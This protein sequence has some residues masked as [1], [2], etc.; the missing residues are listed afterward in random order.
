MNNPSIAITGANGFVGS[1][2]VTS[3]MARGIST[4]K[5]VRTLSAIPLTE[6]RA[7]ELETQPSE[8]L[9]R[10]IDV[11]IH[12][13][14]VSPTEKNAASLDYNGTAALIALAR[15]SGVQKIIFF[16]TVS[17]HEGAVSAY[18]SSKYKMEQLLD[19]GKDAIV[20]PAL[21]IGNGG[22]FLRLLNQALSKRTVPLI[23]NGKQ[24]MQV[25]ALE[26]VVSAVTAIID[27]NLTGS[28]VLANNENFSYKEMFKQIASVYGVYLRFL[29][30]PVFPVKMALSISE[31]IGVKLPVNKENLS[32]LQSLKYMDPG[33]SL[34][35][36]GLRPLSF[37][38]ALLKVKELN[39]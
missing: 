7:F 21:I 8:N 24:P 32:G 22:L 10:G 6:E 26:D 35:K 13:A 9:L 27:R 14:F 5:L 2:L 20:K 17:A 31:M 39:T 25:I 33:E 30:L 34:M 29:P 23:E 11:L 1:A 28:F 38:E 12:C 37:K 19:P 36:L 4:V 15:N 18:G 16:S 3:L